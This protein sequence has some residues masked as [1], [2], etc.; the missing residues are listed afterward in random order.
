MSQKLTRRDFIKAL[1]GAS[2][3]A[4][5]IGGVVTWLL[6]PKEEVRTVKRR[7]RANPYVKAGRPLVPLVRGET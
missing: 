2:I 7:L 3:A 5:S 4:A 6:H 1:I